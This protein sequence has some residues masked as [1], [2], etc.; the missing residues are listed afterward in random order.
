MEIKVF[1]ILPLEVFKTLIKLNT[2]FMS[3]VFHASKIWTSKKEN[4]YVHSRNI[5]KYR[6]LYKEDL[7][8]QEIWHTTF[9]YAR[10][11]G[12]KI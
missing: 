3:K 5:V 4:L 12:M 10:F 8:W 9:I 11:V 6:D 2:G 7:T 1:R